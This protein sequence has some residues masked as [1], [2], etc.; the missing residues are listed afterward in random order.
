MAIDLAE[1]IYISLDEAVRLGPIASKTWF[2][3]NRPDDFPHGFKPT[4]SASGRWYFK[5]NDLV[6]YIEGRIR[7]VN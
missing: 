7:P 3:H 4:D 5:K 2:Y 6:D 1:K